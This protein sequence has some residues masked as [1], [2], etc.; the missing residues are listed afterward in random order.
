MMADAGKRGEGFKKV[1]SNNVIDFTA[2]LIS[3]GIF[4]GYVPVASGTFG[5]LLVVVPFLLLSDYGVNIFWIFLPFLYFLGVWTASYCEELWGK[6]SGRIVID[7]IVGMLVTLVFLP[8]N[9]KIVWLGFFIFRAFDIIKPP[10]IR[11][12][13]RLP[14]G[15]GVMT[16]DLIAGIYANLVLRLIIYF[17]PQVS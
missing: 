12:L 17:F 6:D 1:Q 14:H 5:S 4:I 8:V 9:V 13:E 10:P 7:E 3:S 2:R 16:D 11:W 15:W